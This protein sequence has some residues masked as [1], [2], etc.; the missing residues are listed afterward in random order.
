MGYKAQPQ[1]DTASGDND[2][3]LLH[4][5]EPEDEHLTRVRHP[6]Y[7]PVDRKIRVLSADGSTGKAVNRK[8]PDGFFRI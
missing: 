4:G 6:E 1:S 5:S 7:D 8:T 2:D 3:I